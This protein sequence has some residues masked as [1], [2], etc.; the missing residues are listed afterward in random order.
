M[1]AMA[2][3]VGR[4]ACVILRGLMPQCQSSESIQSIGYMTVI[5]VTVV[6]FVLVYRAY[7]NRV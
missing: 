7:L 2:N 4:A 6:G 1:G 5:V 3:A